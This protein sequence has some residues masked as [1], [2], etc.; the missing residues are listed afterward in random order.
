MARNR[1]THSE[2]F[3]APVHKQQATKSASAYTEVDSRT[4][5]R[6]RPDMYVGNCQQLKRKCWHMVDGKSVWKETY[7][8]EGL[9]KIYEE[10]VSNVADN[11]DNSRVAGIEPGECWIDIK[12]PRVTVRN[13]GLC[14]PVQT[15]N[16]VLIQTIIF[17]HMHS[18]SALGEDRGTGATHGI[19]AKA[20]NVLSNEFTVVVANAEQKKMCT[21]TWRDN[22]RVE[23]K[24]IVKK[25]TDC[26]SYVQV[27]Y[28][29]DPVM[30]GYDKAMTR[31]SYEEEEIE[32]FQWIAEC[33]SFTARV[34][35]TFNGERLEHTLESFAST[36][37]DSDT[38]PK[39][40]KVDQEYDPMAAGLPPLHV[41]AIILDTPGKSF[42]VGFCNH[43][44]NPMG[45]V[46]VNA[47]YK[48]LKEQ[49]LK[50]L[51][52]D[53]NTSKIDI[54]DIKAHISAVVTVT[55]VNNPRWGGGQAKSSLASPT[56]PMDLSVKDVSGINKWG[57]FKALNA[58]L[59]AKTL[60]DLSVVDKSKKRGKYLLTKLGE[61]A[62]LAGTDQGYKCTLSVVEGDSAAGYWSAMLD[63]LPEGKRVNGVLT[64]R[65]KVKN[66]LKC[67]ISK[68]MANAEIKEI[69]T[70]L[71]ITPG[72][73]YTSVKELRYGRM[74]IMT[75]A[76]KDGDHIKSLILACI[77]A[78]APSLF[79]LGFVVD[80][81][82]PYMRLVNGQTL[83]FFHESQYLRWQ[84]A[85]PDAKGWTEKYYKGLGSSKRADIQEDAENQLLVEFELKPKC[86]DVLEMAM[87][88][89]HIHGSQRRDWMRQHDIMKTKDI[90]SGKITISDFIDGY[91]RPYSFSTISRNMPSLLDG[92]TEVQRKIIYASFKKWGRTCA[93][94]TLIKVN[95]FGGYVGNKTK[96]HHGDSIQSSIIG[97][98][99]DHVGSNNI[100]LL[101]GDEGR[102]GDLEAG[103]KNAAQPRY[104]EVHASPLLPFLFRPEDDA[105]LNLSLIDGEVAEP[106][107][108][109]TTIPLA[110]VNG[111]SAV[112]SGWKS[113]IPS[114]DPVMLIDAYL[115]RLDGT[116][117]SEPQPYYRGHAGTNTVKHGVFESRGCGE[118]HD[119][120][121]YTVTC[122]PVGVWNKKYYKKL[123]G[124]VLNETIKEFESDCTATHTHFLVR[125]MK[126]VDE[127]GKPRTLSISDLE[128]TRK[129]D[130]TS[131]TLKAPN[132][133]PEEYSNIRTVME[134]FYTERLSYFEPRKESMLKEMRKKIA[135]YEDQIKYVTACNN[136]TLVFTTETGKPVKRPVIIERIKELELKVG[137]YLGSDGC[138]KICH[139][140]CDEDGIVKLRV[141]IE[142]LQSEIDAVKSKT[143][144]QMWREDL[145]QLKE[146]IDKIY[147]K[148]GNLY[149]KTELP[150]RRRAGKGAVRGRAGRGRGSVRARATATT[151]RK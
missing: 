136:K 100:P 80:Y 107:T 38:V 30:F 121:S 18:G 76:D 117:F 111:T 7:M 45:G 29:A 94:K 39:F 148:E 87:G 102:F 105:I 24:P 51:R 36:F 151:T 79:D 88:P 93:S 147:D 92:L 132:G 33:L 123:M 13:Q 127:A 78:L 23:D 49:V 54:R 116:P 149:N 1:D 46:H 145:L 66:M 14:I 55:G 12:G 56:I 27:S 119:D 118:I 58:S 143:P 40:I 104:L 61:D 69:V 25:Y 50:R 73:V 84:Q 124:W 19:G 67:K 129:E 59:D 109:F 6:L 60:A 150:A 113:K 26:E 71:G 99:Q 63:Y 3:E 128:I 74:M 98:A 21:T 139:A 42:H 77:Y 96:Y 81:K 47:P 75:D 115:A 114:Y 31:R 85:N 28:I 65:G 112:S 15:R 62:T 120:G 86:G 110:L 37:T 144:E 133:F 83:K 64:L 10:L 2:T 17:S 130:L 97:M 95:D 72:K 138:K 141:K 52:S 101:F 90:T 41:R 4:H 44:I 122:L 142:Q 146:E 68:L 125:G 82:T 126:A 20:T 70:R 134:T 57:I 103:G 11:A 106:E 32:V 140:D 48:T 35:V 89:S 91:L 43:V 34:P 22:C 135:K 5:V 53:D 131:I 108:Y 137:F 16:K 9:C 8:P